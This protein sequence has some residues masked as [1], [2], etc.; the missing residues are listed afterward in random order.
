M[1]TIM[2]ALAWMGTGKV[3]E[4]DGAHG[5]ERWH[6]FCGKYKRE[7]FEWRGKEHEIT[8]EH[9]NGEWRLIHSEFTYK[10]KEAVHIFISEFLDHI[11]L[12]PDDLQWL[13]DRLNDFRWSPD[14]L[15]LAAPRLLD[16]LLDMYKKRKTCKDCSDCPMDL[17]QMY[18][19]LNAATREPLE[20]YLK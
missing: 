3:A 19:V 4:F 11:K 9:F 14:P 12:P 13:N 18:S 7:E 16:L 10:Q 15:Q 5:V 20:E 2:E 6:S 8:M 17:I 1:A